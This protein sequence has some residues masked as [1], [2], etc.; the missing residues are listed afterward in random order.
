M[1]T[2]VFWLTL[3]SLVAPGADAPYGL[4][5]VSSVWVLIESLGPEEANIGLADDTVHT[6]VELRLRSAGLRVIS[7]RKRRKS[8]SKT[9][10]SSTSMSRWRAVDGRRPF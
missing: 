5:G 1:Q 2:A 7:L 9:T 3:C 8:P 6:D 4:R 10:P